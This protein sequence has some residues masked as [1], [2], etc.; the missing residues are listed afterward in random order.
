MNFVCANS[1]TMP[2]PTSTSETQEYEYSDHVFKSHTMCTST[3][4]SFLTHY[5]TANGWSALK[6]PCF[7][8]IDNQLQMCQYELQMH[9]QKV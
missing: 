6:Q 2:T 7:W 4:V 8:I 1:I 3:C 5:S 9:S